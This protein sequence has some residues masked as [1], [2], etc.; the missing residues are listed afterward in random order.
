MIL[1]KAGQTFEFDGKKYVIGAE[2]IGNEESEYAGLFGMI[3][4]IRDGEDKDT[5]NETP[6]IYCTFEEPIT[7]YEIRELESIF[8]DLYDEPKKLQDIIL[9]EVI[10]APSMIKTLSEMEKEEKVITVYA[11]TVDWATQDASGVTVEVKSDLKSAKRYMRQVLMEERQCGGIFENRGE[12]GIVEESTELSYE[13]YSEGYFCSS[14]FSIR[15]EE[16]ELR[17]SP[18]FINKLVNADK[19]NQKSTGGK[20]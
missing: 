16:K 9:D 17:C 5:E 3:T 15:I 10:M 4:E 1:N 8:S 6:D 7:P 12:D 20:Q 11:I 14:H 19:I 13:I 18:E 2:I